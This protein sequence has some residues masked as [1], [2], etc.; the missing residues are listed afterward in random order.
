MASER[1]GAVSGASSRTE[2]RQQDPFAV[3]LACLVFGMYSLSFLHPVGTIGEGAPYSGWGYFP[4]SPFT[5]WTRWTG[6]FR[7][8]T[9]LVCG[10]PIPFCGSVQFAWCGVGPTLLF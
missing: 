1:L 5:L 4:K 6:E 9:C 3:P 8:G 2:A 10:C 7:L